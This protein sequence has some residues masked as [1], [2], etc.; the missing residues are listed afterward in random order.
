MHA[1]AVVGVFVLTKVTTIIVEET[2]R[3]D[4]VDGLR[5]K[6]RDTFNRFIDVRIQD[7]FY[8]VFWTNIP[9]GVILFLIDSPCVLSSIGEEI[10]WKYGAN[11]NHSSSRNNENLGVVIGPII[12]TFLVFQLRRKTAEICGYLKQKTSKPINCVFQRFEELTQPREFNGAPKSYLGL[13]P[14]VD[15]GRF[16]YAG[17][18]GTGDSAEKVT[19]SN[20]PASPSQ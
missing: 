16:Y 15:D 6:I 12:Y 10:F 8:R 1:A 3:E 14:F 19:T 18:L 2:F 4:G 17:P 11:R 7:C 13:T 20:L 9:Y 5:K